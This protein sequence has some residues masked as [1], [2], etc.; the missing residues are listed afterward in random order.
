[1]AFRY[2]V[3]KTVQVKQFEPLVIEAEYSTDKNLTV[4]A[5]NKVADRVED[6]VVER[7]KEQIANY[8]GLEIREKKKNPNVVEV[9]WEE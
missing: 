3:S 5:W 9:P 6:F 4:E 8:K 2:K 1:M 7:L